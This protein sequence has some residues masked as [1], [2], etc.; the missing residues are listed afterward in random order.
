MYLAYLEEIVIF[1]RSSFWQIYKIRDKNLINLFQYHFYNV[2]IDENSKCRIEFWKK[3]VSKSAVSADVVNIETELSK[4][5]WKIQY[6]FA[7]I[8]MQSINKNN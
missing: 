1:R 3:I 7:K 4:E 5:Y 2:Y 6:T 8:C